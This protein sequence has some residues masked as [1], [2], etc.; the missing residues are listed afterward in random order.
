MPPNWFEKWIRV[1]GVDLKGSQL[2]AP[3]VTTFT[4]V[5]FDHPAPWQ[6]D[7]FFV[8]TDKTQ[9]KV[10]AKLAGRY[11]LRATIRWERSDG[12]EFTTPDRNNSCFLAYLT[13]NGSTMAEHLEDS[14]MSA[15]PV[16]KATKTV[17]HIL[18]EGNLVRDDFI[19]LFIFHQGDIFDNN[20]MPVSVM[21]N[22]WLTLRRLGPRTV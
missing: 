1:H 10:P 17:M 4:A 5:S 12:M 20:N 8:A 11:S 18:W 13:K 19:K 6:S 22:V 7:S 2:L 9:I 15:A 3:N 16:V 21:V 14:H